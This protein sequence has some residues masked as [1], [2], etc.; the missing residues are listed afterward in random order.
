MFRGYID[1]GFNASDIV[2]GSVSSGDIGDGIVF[3]GNIASGQVGTYHVASGSVIA[4]LMASGSVLSGSIG[5]GSIS[6]FAVASGSFLGFE[7]GSGSI[8]SGRIA[9]GQIGDN[10]LQQQIRINSHYGAITTDT[11][12]ATITFDLNASDKHQVTMAASGRVLA[13]SNGQNGQSFLVT[14][15]QDA[16]GGRFPTW[17]ST[18]KWPGSTAP[19][20]TS[21][22]G[23][24][25]V[26]SFLQV[27][28]GNYYGFTVGQNL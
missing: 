20:L 4:L 27:T 13:I 8:V 21:G 23:K 18:I 15:I 10:H 3:S 9:S 26:F 12:G 17:F 6:R 22:G 2:S 14:L 16:T 24:I 19:S 5:S 1:P 7:F 28:S 11:D 25:D